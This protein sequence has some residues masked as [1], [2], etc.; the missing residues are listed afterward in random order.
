MRSFPPSHWARRRRFALL[1]RLVQS[2]PSL[3]RPLRLL[4]VGGTLACWQQL[5][6]GA[7]G[8]PVDITLLNVRPQPTI[9]GFTAIVGDAR[10]LSHYADG[11]FDVVFSQSTIGH[12][13]SLLDQ[14]AMAAEV[15]RV[16]VR[17]LLQTPN[18]HFPID[19]HSRIPF[20]HWIRP[21][22]R[23]RNLTKREIEGL[24]PCAEIHHERVVGLTK[25]FV[26]IGP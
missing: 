22:H 18:H 5:D 7:F 15:Q 12:V 3:D 6:I 24:F 10:N 19:W 1:V 8:R 21:P 25:S 16:G 11:A 26:V 4:D 14:A 13:G 20:V 17:F 9:L 23:T 2:V